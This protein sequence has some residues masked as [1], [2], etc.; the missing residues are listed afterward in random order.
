[1]KYIE[2]EKIDMLPGRR[3]EKNDTFSFRC[4]AGLSC[5]NRCCRNINLFL[6]PYDVVRLKNRLGIDSD[7]FLDR[8]VHIIMREGNFFPDVLLAMAENEQKSCPFLTASGCSVYRDRPD[9]CRSFPVELGCLYD[10]GTNTVQTLHFFRPPDFCMGRHEPDTWTVASWTDNQQAGMYHEM[11][12]RWSEIKR[13]FQQN[14]WGSEGI[15][16]PK[17]KM[18]FMA[19]YNMDRFRDFIFNSSFLKRYKVKR[20]VLKRIKSDETA[21][22]RFGFAWVKLAVWGIPVKAIRPR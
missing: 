22:L 11:T 19:T 20:Q 18:A 21:L 6:Y 17:G 3:L 1:M 10:A 8:H 2:P 15:D 16:G 7:E 4:H 9:T 5:F 12:R 14:P 13:L